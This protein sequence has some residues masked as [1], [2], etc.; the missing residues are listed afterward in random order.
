MYSVEEWTSEHIFEFFS[1]LGSHTVL[2]I[3]YQTLSQYSDREPPNE[4]IKCRCGRQKIAILDEYLAIGSM[5]G[6]VRS[7]ID[8]RTCSSL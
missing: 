1:P 6:G 3:P 4:D 2:V 7:T 5:T 8:G